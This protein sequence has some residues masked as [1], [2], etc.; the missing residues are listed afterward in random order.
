M[1]AALPIQ[2]LV[3]VLPE[4]VAHPVVNLKIEFRDFWKLSL[5][6]MKWTHNRIEGTV[7][8]GE[9]VE[10][11]VDVLDVREPI[12]VKIKLTIIIIYVIF[13]GGFSVS[14]KWQIVIVC[15]C[16]TIPWVRLPWS[17][18]L[19]TH[20]LHFLSSAT[21]TTPPSLLHTHI[22][23]FLSPATPMFT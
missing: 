1:F 4:P 17:P 3:K 10:T 23:H 20:I 18:L 11:E 22:L 9:P 15:V 7:G 16:N 8:H 6:R 19:R 12:I 13:L 21:P 5:Y 14:T 2:Q